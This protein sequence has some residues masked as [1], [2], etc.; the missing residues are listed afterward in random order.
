MGRVAENAAACKV[1]YDKRAM[2]GS[3]FEVLL[4][5]SDAIAG[6]R[7]LDELLHVLAPTLREAVQFDY[8]AVFVHD[9]VKNLMNLHLIEL[10]FDVAIPTSSIAP[11]RSPAGRCFLSQQ[12]LIIDDVDTEARFDPDIIAVLQKYEIKSCCYQPLTTSVRRLG[13]LSFGSRQPHL[14]PES[15]MP[16]LRR[17]A[18]QVAVAVDNA[19]HFEEAQR[20][21]QTLAKE[22]DRLQILLDVNNAVAS[23]LSLHDFLES[24][25]RYLKRILSHEMVSIS[26]YEADQRQLRLYSLIFPGGHGIIREGLTMPVEGTILGRVLTSRKPLVVNTV[27]PDDLPPDILEMAK[28]E[29]LKSGAILPLLVGDKAFGTLEVISKKDHSVSEEDMELLT[30]LAAQVAIGVAN[31]LAYTEIEDLKRKLSEE[32]LYLE[33]EIRSEYFD[34][35]IGE[36]S[37][38]VDVLEQVRTVAETDSTVLILGETGTGK[39]LIAR[40]IHNFSPRRQKT[41]VKLNCSAI[42]TGLLESELFGHERGAFTGAIAQKIGRMELA[43]KGTLFLDEIGDIP[44]ELQ[45]KLLR[46]LQEREFERL[47][48]N[49]TLKSD[50]RLIAATNRHLPDMVAAREFRT[51]LYYRLNVFPIRLPPLRERIGDVPRLVRHF[52]AKYA[53]RMNKRIDTIPADTMRALSRWHWPGNIRE[54]ENFIERAVILSKGNV[55]NVPVSELQQSAPKAMPV[56]AA[57]APEQAVTLEASEREHILKI[58]RETRGVLSG[59]NGAAARLGLKRTTL[60]GKMKKLGIDRERI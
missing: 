33:D 21:Q 40:A 51:D 1:G 50:F 47:G 19:L 15:E 36:S 11:E 4:R 44:L 43:D 8:V 49:R 13:A 60:Q 53:S 32:K 39:E 28:R 45:P 22:R 29:G 57:A 20:Y 46:A 3:R 59:P 24:V 54:L 16:F 7:S 37:Q 42:P 9:P 18:D 35:I 48:S 55:L 25:S 12:P 14:F 56:G 38:L 52:A 58:L 30:P 31:A 27:N 23:R 5:I 17:V 34:E 10:F 26:L 41:F 6:A 2:S